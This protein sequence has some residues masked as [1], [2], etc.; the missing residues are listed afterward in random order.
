MPRISIRTYPTLDDSKTSANMTEPIPP[1]EQTDIELESSIVLSELTGIGTNK[2]KEQIAKEYEDNC[3]GLPP[4]PN[5]NGGSP[6][7]MMDVAIPQAVKDALQQVI[8]DNDFPISPE[9]IA[10]MER[11][12]AEF[13]LVDPDTIAAQHFI[14]TEGKCWTYRKELAD[15]FTGFTYYPPET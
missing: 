9:L 1:H 3:L 8:E 6:G 11:K 13:N 4:A 2:S 15:V 14:I 7:S 5:L 10:W 12:V